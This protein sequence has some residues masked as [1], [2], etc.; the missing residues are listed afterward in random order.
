MESRRRH[1][2]AT[3]LPGPCTSAGPSSRRC[4]YPTAGGVSPAGDQRER[5]EQG[6]RSL[7]PG[8][9][10]PAGSGL[11]PLAFCSLAG[12]PN[13]LRQRDSPPSPW[14]ASLEPLLGGAARPSPTAPVDPQ[15][16][17]TG[18]GESTLRAGR[19]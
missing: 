7:L 8:N 13:P 16:S 18:E 3:I 1:E 2:N 15:T 10:K 19:V 11:E 4:V 17:E 6:E 12:R 14:G 5:A 9:Q